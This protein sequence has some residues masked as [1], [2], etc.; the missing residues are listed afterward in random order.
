MSVGPHSERSLFIW[1]TTGLNDN[2]AQL[3]L[4]RLRESAT[5]LVKVDLPVLMEEQKQR[6][7]THLSCEPPFVSVICTHIHVYLHPS[8]FNSHHQLL[9]CWQTVY[10]TPPHTHLIL[11]IHMHHVSSRVNMDNSMPYRVPPL[12]VPVKLRRCPPPFVRSHLALRA[13]CVCLRPP[14]IHPA[15]AKD[16]SKGHV[17][18]RG[19]PWVLTVRGPCSFEEQQGWMRVLRSLITPDWEKQQ[20]P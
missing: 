3:A 14:M 4:S 10:C 7:W 11:Y 16:H 5:C 1:G 20:L 18:W 9:W 13:S 8:A 15:L 2:F 12:T 17:T 6:W 19:C